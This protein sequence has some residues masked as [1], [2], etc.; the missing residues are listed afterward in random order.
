MA[1]K[2]P[3]IKG[4]VKQGKLTFSQNQQNIL[5]RWLNNLIGKEVEVIIKPW[6]NSRSGQQNKYY[7]GVVISMI[8][9]ETGYTRDELHEF[10]KILFLSKSITIGE[11]EYKTSISTSK[12][13]TDEFE[14]YIGAIKDFAK[15]KISLHIPEPNEIDL[16]SF[17]VDQKID[18]VDVKDIPWLI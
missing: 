11:K 18:E 3:K 6:K 7:W 5:T 8:S 13:K 16:D 4:L 12:L 9:E 15:L 17:V 2:I 14:D 1:L 10:F